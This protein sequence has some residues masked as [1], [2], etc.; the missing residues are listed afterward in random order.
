MRGHFNW[1]NIS[2]TYLMFYLKNMGIVW[3]LGI[4]SLIFTRS[5]N[6]FMVVPAFFIWTLVELM[7]FQPN[8]YDNN[9]LLYIAYLFLCMFV[10]DYVIE[11]CHKI[12]GRIFPILLV[13]VLIFI[14][15][16]SAV[17]TMGREIVSD[18]EL[19]SSDEV[20]MCR[21][22]E[23]NTQPKD[24]ILTD[25]RHNNGV[26]SLTG[27]NIVCGSSSFL[28]YHGVDYA[29][30]EQD[31]AAMYGNPGDMTLFDKYDVAYVYICDSERYNYNITSEDAFLENFELIHQE[32]RVN[33]YK[34]ME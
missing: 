24:V 21:F 22:I 32:G 5:R 15:S 11:I 17:L 34:R 3:V 18:Y 6:Y 27:R 23:E 29:A 10:A 31:V 9:K 25:T 19:Y 33:L 8:E 14:S 16:I 4:V 26:V 30:R 7:L 1:A 28:Y 20:R 12:K 2:D 13:T